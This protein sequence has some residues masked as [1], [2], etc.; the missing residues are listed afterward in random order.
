[1]FSPAHNK[2]K[3]MYSMFFWISGEEYRKPDERDL[4]GIL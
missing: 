2:K 4:K 1:M 3:S